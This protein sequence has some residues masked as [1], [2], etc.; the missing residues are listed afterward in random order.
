MSNPVKTSSRT[1]LAIATIVT[2]LAIGRPAIFAAS[3][4]PLPRVNGFDQTQS[5]LRIVRTHT[6]GAI[7]DAARQVA[8]WSPLAYGQVID[9]MQLIRMLVVEATR[10]GSNQSAG[11]NALLGVSAEY[12]GKRLKLEQLGPLLGLTPDETGGAITPQVMAQP[13]SQ[14]RTAIA[15]LMMRAALLHTDIAMAPAS[16]LPVAAN[17][18]FTVGAV[19]LQDGRESSVRNIAVQYSI[20]RE[21][22]ALVIPAAVGTTAGRQWYLATLSYLQSDRNYA[23]L[24]PHLE[25]A[26]VTLAGDARIWLWSGAAYENL[27]APAVQV[28]ADGTSARIESPT[29]LYAR[30]EQF[31]RRG[32]DVDPA[33]AECW[34]RLAR[35]RQL[36]GHPDEAADLLA[37][38]ESRLTA[39][40]LRYYAAL[41]AGRAAES[42]KR[43]DAARAAYERAMGLFPQAQSP[44]LALAELATRDADQ[45]QAL[46]SV[47]TM[48]ITSGGRYDI[49]PWWNY[50]VALVANWASLVDDMRKSAAA[51][52][53]RR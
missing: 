26:R 45:A 41:F 14:A 1:L 42:L 25:T 4:Q 38:A 3:G 12:R 22:I 21:A 36:S 35:V 39:P 43:V 9:D 33:C 49:D 23:A 52:V 37:K 5:W 48:F 20:A 11:P 10:Q 46:S 16:E 6:S 40:V 17:G 32:L 30:A 44:R 51:L 28:A 2:G 50:D 8:S 24:L 18:R 34:L 53:E 29:L 13:D 7:D 19:Q 15:A 47:R 31:Y 27:A